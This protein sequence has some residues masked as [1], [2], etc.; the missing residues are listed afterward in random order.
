[1]AEER[2]GLEVVGESPARQLKLSLVKKLDIQEQ[3]ESIEGKETGAGGET[4]KV[5]TVVRAGF[6]WIM[7]DEIRLYNDCIASER[8]CWIPTPSLSSVIFSHFNFFPSDFI[9][10][11]PQGL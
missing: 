8:W 4:W 5:M 3:G 11:L 9:S 2:L 1:M 10:G 6:G 7:S